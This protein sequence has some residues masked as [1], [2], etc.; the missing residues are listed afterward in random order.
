MDI[1]LFATVFPLGRSEA[2][3]TEDLLLDVGENGA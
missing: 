1:K 2:Y 3:S